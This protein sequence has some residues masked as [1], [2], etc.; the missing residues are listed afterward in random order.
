MNG[1]EVPRTLFW[2][3]SFSDYVFRVAT[4]DGLLFGFSGKYKIHRL[5][6]ISKFLTTLQFSM[7]P[8]FT[9]CYCKASKVRMSWHSK[10]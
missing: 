10:I 9:N 8:R 1:K 6:F 2:C 7:Y 3:F 5:L 4:G